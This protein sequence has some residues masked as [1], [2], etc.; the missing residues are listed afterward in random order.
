MRSRCSVAF[1]AT[2]PALW[3]RRRAE[4]REIL[5]AVVTAEASL[6][7]RRLV[8][9][10]ANIGKRCRS[11]STKKTNRNRSLSHFSDHGPSDAGSNCSP[12]ALLIP[13]A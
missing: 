4:H 1:G 3:D 11:R 7:A 2:T 12:V 10:Y 6:A 5:D 9:H 8:E 13:P